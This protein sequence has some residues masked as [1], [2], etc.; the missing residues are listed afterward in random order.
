MSWIPLQTFPIEHDLSSLHLALRAAAV[1]HRVVER[2]G[3]QILYVEQSW[4]PQAA[5][6]LSR[7]A[8]GELKAQTVQATQAVR[9][10][11]RINIKQA[12]ITLALILLSALGYGIVAIPDL[13]QWQL[14]LAFVPM[15][16]I[17]G[18]WIDVKSLQDTLSRGEYWRLTTPAFLHFSILH[19]VFNSLWTWELGRRIE[20]LNGA[21]FASIFFVVTA[22]A[23]N[24]CQY[25]WASEPQQFGGMSGVVYAYVGYIALRHKLNPHPLTAMPPGIIIFM[26]VWLAIC[27]TGIVDVFIGGGIANGAHLGGLLAGLLVALV[28][29]LLH[30]TNSEQR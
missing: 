3:Q 30:K 12:P 1:P 26:L 22:F 13:I 18:R 19:L 16:I 8:A 10:R 11:Q 4:Q 5:E 7:W 14:R 24:L 6:M 17:D 23:A 20:R 2:D 15:D 9:P 29:V 21:V 25:W 28:Q 27:L